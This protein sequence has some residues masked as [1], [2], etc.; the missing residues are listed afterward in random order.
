MV[1]VTLGGVGF[2]AP[3]SLGLGGESL[4]YKCQEGGQPELLTA[5][6]GLHSWPEAKYA[7]GIRVPVPQR[8][9]ALQKCRFVHS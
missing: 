7:G 9:V 6:E 8:E 5:A 3:L 1:T 2:S 4:M